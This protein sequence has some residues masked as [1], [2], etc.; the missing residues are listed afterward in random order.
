MTLDEIFSTKQTVLKYKDEGQY[1][2]FLEGLNPAELQEHIANEYGRIPPLPSSRNE[3]KRLINTS[4]KEFR[5]RVKST[6]V[7][8]APKRATKKAAKEATNIFNSF[9]L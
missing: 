2:E 9:G 6:V 8:K 1:L 7:Q 4:L 5:K 3:K